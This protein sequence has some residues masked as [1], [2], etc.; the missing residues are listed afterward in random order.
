MAWE[1]PTLLWTAKAG[2]DLSAAASQYKFVKMNADNEVVLCNGA[3]DVPA[4]VLQNRPDNGEMASIMSFGI[5]KV[6]GDGDLDA[7]D[8]IGTSSDGEA[9]EKVPGTDTSDYIAG[10]VIEGN[11][12]AGGYATAL[13]N[14]ASPARAA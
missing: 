9:E 12:A 3:T 2:A 5:S 7:G 13:I 11:A 6:R 10:Q 1:I 4:G 14:C 8:L